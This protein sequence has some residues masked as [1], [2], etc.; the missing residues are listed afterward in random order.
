MAINFSAQF[1][2]NEKTAIRVL[3]FTDTSTGFT[4]AKG[5][6]SVTFP[7]GSQVIH[8][9][10]ISPDI[11]APSGSID[12]TLITDI[13]NTVLTGTY[14]IN[15]VALDATPTEYTLQRSFDFNWEKPIKN[16]TNESDVVIPTITFRDSTAYETSGNFTGTLTRNFYTTTPSTSEV[17]VITKT[18]T[19]DV[20]IPSNASKYYEGIYPVKSDISVAYTHSSLSWLTILYVDLLEETYDI[21]EAPTQDEL[22]G[23]MNEYKDQI[24]EYKSTNP[25]QYELLNEEYDLVVSLY[26]H[27]IAR[28]QTGTLDGC[29]PILDQL[30]GLLPPTEPYTYKATQM[31][32]FSVN[33]TTSLSGS[34]TAGT[35]AKFT[36]GT[37]I[38]DSIIT[39]LTGKIGIGKVPTV[40]LDVNGAIQGTSIVKAGGTS[41]QF[42]KADGSVDASAYLT[43]VTANSPVVSTGGTTPVI[44]IPAAT[45]SVSG[46]LTNT[47]WNT[48]NAKQGALT[49]TTMGT[50]GPSTLVGDTLNIPQYQSV[51]TNPITGL[52]TTNYVSKF[53]SASSIGDSNIQDSGTLITLGSNS[54]VNGR[55]AVGLT[56]S[57]NTNLFVSGNITG[58]ITSQSIY[59]QSTIQSDV[60]SSAII[61]RSSPSTVAASF[62]L[63]NLFHFQTIQGTIGA[64]SSITTQIGFDAGASMVGATNNWGFRG[65]IPAAS[66]NW[67]LYMSGTANNYLAGS[68]GIG[69]TSLA[70]YNLR[71][72]KNITGA[73]TSYA[74]RQDGIVQSDSTTAAYG[75]RNDMNTAAASFTVGS[76][77]HYYATEGTI[78]AGSAVT[79]QYG[80]TVTSSMTSATN[81]YGFF[82]AIASGTNRWNLYMAGTALNY[83]AGNLLIGST[84]DNGIKLQVTGQGYFSDSVG[85]G[86]TT[87]TG[88]NLRVSKSIT[89]ATA[90]YSVSVDGVIQSGVTASSRSYYSNPSTVAASFTL[91]N[92]YHFIAD[93]STIGAGSVVTNQYGFLVGASVIGATNN[94]AYYGNIPSGTGRWNIYMNGTADN[95]MAGSLGVGNSSLTGYNLRVQKN[96]TG[97]TSA[98]GVLSAGTVQSDVTGTAQYYTTTAS[99]VATAFTLTTLVHYRANQST[100]GA[101]SSVTNQYGFWADTTITGATNNYGFTGS[102]AAAAGSWNLYMVGTAKNY[103]AGDLGIGVSTNNASAKVQIDSTTQGFLPPRMTETQRT[104]IASPATGLIVYQTD[105]VEGLWLRVSTGWVEL[106]VV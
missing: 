82:G 94:Y 36:G 3:R 73:T 11:S 43:S 55:L 75:M 100:I 29:K 24:E 87:L 49:L 10:F 78:G 33:F 51:L 89:G 25:S 5:N 76:Y 84:T 103:L 39:E 65:N 13:D 74:I 98:Y 104:A 12:I 92:L 40:T 86:A 30:L 44:S 68:L 71:I 2:V 47:D 23:L 96:I 15:F 22:V 91:T 35:I 80:F 53:T 6:F 64:G 77:N 45:T 9:D 95:Y 31:L 93:Q 56:A 26:S 8:T 70:N 14:V 52:G 66:N 67:N 48:F 57:V 72:T 97:G 61:F 41:S 28:F 21:R 46:Y 37:S 102:I 1:I 81:N 69:N 54:Y 60:T 42:L 106:T 58:G 105:G 4:L 85:I 101:G 90:A 16:I 88:Y 19:G 34:G 63:P 62:T 20:L 79:N 99:T 50:S 59:S 38:G 27:I 83:L 17:G 7:D 18:S 32:P